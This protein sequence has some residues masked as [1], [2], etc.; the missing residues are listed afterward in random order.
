MVSDPNT[1]TTTESLRRGVRFLPVRKGERAPESSEFFPSL[2]LEFR[3]SPRLADLR[4][5]LLPHIFASRGD[6]AGADAGAP[7]RPMGRAPAAILIR[8]LS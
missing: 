1:Q 6:L 2:H 7:L 4:V 3:F 8:D 5:Y